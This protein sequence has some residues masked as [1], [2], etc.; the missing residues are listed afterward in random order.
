MFLIDEKKGQMRRVQESGLNVPRTGDSS[1]V[2]GTP[3]NRIGVVLEIGGHHSTTPKTPGINDRRG[4]REVED[5]TRTK[6]IDGGR[7]NGSFL[8]QNFLKRKFFTGRFTI[9]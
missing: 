3:P 8:V 6:Q 9:R 7:T 2:R 4:K 5:K 1:L